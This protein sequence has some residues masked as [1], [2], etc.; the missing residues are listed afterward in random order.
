MTIAII[1]TFLVGYNTGSI[2]VRKDL[3]KDKAYFCYIEKN[4]KRCF[5]VNE[6]AYARE[7]IEK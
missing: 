2:F 7:T 6:D 1:L 5:E 3:A 4:T